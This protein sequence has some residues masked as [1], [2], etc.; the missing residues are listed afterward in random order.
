MGVVGHPVGSYSPSRYLS[1]AFPMDKVRGS[2]VSGKSGV[3]VL[4]RSALSSA[5]RRSL[6]RARMTKVVVL[7]C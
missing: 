1:A 7:A 3:A 6:Y 2:Q 5:P 4:P